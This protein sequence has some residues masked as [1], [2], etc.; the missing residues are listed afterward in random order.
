[1]CWVPCCT[2]THTSCSG[3]HLLLHTQIELESSLVD[4]A[5]MALMGL[6]NVFDPDNILDLEAQSLN[7]Q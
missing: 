7:Q 2:P 3:I 1:M 4:E 5:T 6:R